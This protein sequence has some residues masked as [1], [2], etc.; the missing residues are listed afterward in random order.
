MLDRCFNYSTLHQVIFM[1]ELLKFLILIL[2]LSAC[3]KTELSEVSKLTSEKTLPDETGYGIEFIFSDSAKVKAKITAPRMDVYN[4]EDPRV[5]LSEGIEAIFYDNTFRPNAYLF[6]R[7]G[8]RKLRERV[9][10]L[11]DSV[12]VVNLKG[13]TLR[14][15]EL[16]WDE[17]TDKVFSKK[18]VIVKTRAEI[19]KSEGF[20]SDPSFSFYKFYN[21][22]GIISLKD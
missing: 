6:A 5:E 4:R 15:S 2:L 14:T 8:T 9:I 19:I 3:K 10:T 13:D 16:V 22:R 18:Y 17:K 12:V 7:N 11:K 1:P 21:I 20:E